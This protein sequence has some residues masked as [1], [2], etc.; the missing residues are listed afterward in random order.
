MKQIG[1]EKYKTLS[2]RYAKAL[3]QIAE[4]RNEIDKFNKELSEVTN[5]IS[6]NP[7]IEG[8]FVNPVIKIP[9]KKE[10]L[11]KSFEGKVDEEIYNFLDLLIDKNR[12]FLLGSIK[13]LFEQ[14]IAEKQNI[15]NVEAQT[16]I[17]LDEDMRGKLAEKLEKITGKNINIIN[18]IDESIIGG[19]ILRFGGNVIDGS[20]QTQLKKIQKQLI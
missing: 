6:E 2:E 18:V 11:Q 16:V 5:A 9:D 7:D 12:I 20:V 14:K 4:E 10:V 13:S 3:W 17:P 8:F 1:M 19:V 15:L